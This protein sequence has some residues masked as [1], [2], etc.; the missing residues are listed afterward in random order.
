MA[1]V[2]LEKIQ[3]LGLQSDL[4]S[5]MNYLSKQGVL[6]LRRNA[7]M[8]NALEASEL[9]KL[10][11][12]YRNLPKETDFSEA[13]EK[14]VN[15]LADPKQYP[16]SRFGEKAVE[17]ADLS[18]ECQRRI[19]FLDKQITQADLLVH[20]AKPLFTLKRSVPAQAYAAMTEQ[21]RELMLFARQFAE[22]SV[23]IEQ[24]KLNYQKQQVLLEQLTA[25]RDL[26]LDAVERKSRF[27]YF[28]G[29]LRDMAQLV[30]LEK[31][32]AE[33]EDIAAACKLLSRQNDTVA[34]IVAVHK[35][36][37]ALCERLLL[38]C[39][40]KPLPTLPLLLPESGVDFSAYYKEQS[41][42]AKRLEQLLAKNIVE[43]K[44]LTVH[45]PQ[46]EVLADFYR[47]QHERFVAINN[48]AQSG[49]MFVLE[50]FV[51]AKIKEEL[52]KDLQAHYAVALS[53]LEI[54]PD[55]AVPVLLNNPQ[56]F[57]PYESVIE[58][59]SMPDYRT[60]L[61]PTVILAPCYAFF[62]G[63]MLS[64]IGY[65]L[66]FCLGA[67][68]LL[69]SKRV[70]GNTKRF[71]WIFAAGG[72][73]AVLW[74]LALGSFF[75]DL[76]AAVAKTFGS[77]FALTPLFADPFKE[78]M[79]IMLTSVAL[80]MA[81]IALGMF[82]N[83]CKLCKNGEARVAFTEIAPWYFI[84]A[85]IG[86]TIMGQAWGKW[87]SLTACLVIVL[88]SPKD[89]K[90]PF[91]QLI[92]GILKLY[93]I[94]AFVGD[95]LS[96][97]RI[98]ALI[99]STSVIAMVVNMFAGMI[100]FTFPGVIFSVIILILGH[101]MNISL[102]GLSAYV[103]TTRLHYVEL[104]GKFYSGGGELFKPLAIKTKYTEPCKLK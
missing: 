57:K 104:F 14:E 78:P 93:D 15:H 90:N 54:A 6:E 13:F 62:F 92:S 91:M 40:V 25:W 46:W 63:A 87:L 85:G 19:D 32:L 47:I 37:Q 96:Y 71:M 2:K 38:N 51:P 11:H 102:S 53:T 41:Q 4:A 94:T 64:D 48:L 72:F 74:G 39:G 31:A 97:T 60:D 45:V 24:L 36:S 16:L 66:I 7:D 29:T 65:G 86:L 99:L 34:V 23:Q 55:E 10:A 9:D 89:T 76:P 73:F 95:I 49:Q 21:Q 44:E 30:N 8:E 22:L 42:E 5:I 100:G 3:L 70:Q 61:D 12:A 88:L 101:T 18:T 80:G 79:L 98:T 56:P 68:Y 75:G 50:G 82:L 52:F 84:F 83:I 17:F 20:R 1:I 27:R 33:R 103:H 43:A 28:L 58:E 67:L 77:D 59:F 69:F 35:D 81:H 26:Q